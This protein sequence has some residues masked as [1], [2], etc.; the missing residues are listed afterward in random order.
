MMYGWSMAKSITS[1]LVG[2]LIKQGKLD[3]T[4]PAPVPEWSDIKDPRHAITLEHL[5]QQTSGLDFLELQ[6]IIHL[7]I[8]PELYLTTQAVT[9]IFLPV[10]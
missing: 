10:L 4:K 2:T 3:V 8:N 7:N 9:A 1:A 6:Q 5:L